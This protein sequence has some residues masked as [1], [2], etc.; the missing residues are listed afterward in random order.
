MK[1]YNTALVIGRFQPFHK[2]H[3]FLIK[4]ALDL[5]DNVVIGIG[6]ANVLNYDN[7]FPVA[8]R[9]QMV[10]EV[11][12]KEH[13][14]KFVK[15][16]VLLDD[17]NHDEKWLTET[18]KKTGKV[19]I[20]V[21][22]NDWVNRIF[23]QAG[24]QTHMIPYYKREIYEGT[25]IREAMRKRAELRPLSKQP[26]P[27]NAKKVFNGKLFAVY[28]WEQELFDGSVT[29]FEK[30]KTNDIVSIVPVTTDGKIMICQQEQPGTEPFIGVFG[31][32]IDTG[33]TPLEAAKR[34]LLEETG[35]IAEEFILWE[36]EQIFTH[37]DFAVYLFIA[38]NCKKITEPELETGEK[39]TVKTVTFEEFLDLVNKDTFRGLEITIKLLRA[40]LDKN[41]FKKVK[42][43]LS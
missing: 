3:L 7:P 27:G 28:Q 32:R 21:G 30:V 31:G 17:Y 26:I 36:A 41:E 19:D 4:Q 43:L 35:C 15:K 22:N 11:I 20:V 6:S 38:K 29:T 9:I 39:I 2:G 14:E 25:R 34:E 16:I 10:H 37:F 40:Q 13:L 5:A 23:K 42:K 18:L 24:Y 8:E 1:K 33:E 12:K